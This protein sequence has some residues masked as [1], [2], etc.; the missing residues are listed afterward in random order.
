VK[1]IGWIVDETNNEPIVL[2]GDANGASDDNTVTSI[3]ESSN[4]KL[5]VGSIGDGQILV[6]SGTNLIGRTL[7]DIPRVITTSFFYGSGVLNIG[8]SAL[9]SNAIVVGVQCVISTVFDLA[10]STVVVGWVANPIGLMTE[11]EITPSVAN[12]YISQRVVAG[13]ANQQLQL[14]VNDSGATKGSGRVVVHYIL[15]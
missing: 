10:E 1:K 3:H 7:N 12:T 8:T 14:V 9:P 13:A 5:T 4:A 11:S 2:A 6:R 15:S